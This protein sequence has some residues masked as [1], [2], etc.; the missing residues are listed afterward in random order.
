MSEMLFKMFLTFQQTK[1]LETQYVSFVQ[2]TLA[3]ESNQN[4]V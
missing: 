4:L 2:L 1:D 3:L